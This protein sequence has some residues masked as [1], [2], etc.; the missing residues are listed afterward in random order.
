[1]KQIAL[2]ILIGGLAVL[3][4]P[5]YA[6][7]QDKP[8]NKLKNSQ[9]DGH[10]D[11]YVAG[12]AAENR[13]AREVRHELI[14]L[15]YFDVFDD[16]GFTVNGDTVTLVGQVTRPILKDEAERAA[17]KVEGVE[18]VVN[19]IEVL[20]I[21][22]FDDQI[23]LRLYRAIYGDPDLSIRYG[24]RALPPI[25]IIVKNG[26]VRLEGVVGNEMDR[27][28]VGMRAAAVPGT[29]EVVNSLKVEK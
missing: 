23:R 7:D 28:I 29:F 18:K 13:I 27:Q 6:A 17:K 2:A 22:P 11:P 26:H 3:P 10:L 14:M 4:S 25:H 1:M 12:P 20:P 8:Q 15:P 16:L 5:V 21:S 24:H 9:G 19:N